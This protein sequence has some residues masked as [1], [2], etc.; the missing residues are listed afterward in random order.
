MVS[1][2]KQAFC[3]QHCLH[4]LYGQRILLP[5]PNSAR[6]PACQSLTETGS[7][8]Q[9]QPQTNRNHQD[10]SVYSTSWSSLTWIKDPR[11]VA[12]GTWSSPFQNFETSVVWRARLGAVGGVMK[13]GFGSR[14]GGW[15]PLEFRLSASLLILN[16]A[17]TLNPRSPKLPCQRMKHKS[18]EFL[19]IT[20]IS[21]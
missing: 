2:S 9:K 4:E 20:T 14:T 5:W 16:T 19:A 10:L 13:C 15:N 3:L 17:A 11:A 8:A 18:F 1:G 6:I 7:L 12:K 21:L